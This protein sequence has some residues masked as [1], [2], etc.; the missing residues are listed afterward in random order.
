MLAP[1]FAD[2]SWFVDLSALRDPALVLPTVAQAVEAEDLVASLKGKR[3]LLVL[4]NLEQVLDAALDVAGLLRECP[5]L[6]V[7]VTS[8][9]PLRLTGEWNYPV[10]PHEA[11]EAEVL[12]RERALAVLPTDVVNAADRG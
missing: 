12:F 7:V 3:A 11:G 4:D 2:G 5:R 10:P 6:R 1:G 8:R 9:E